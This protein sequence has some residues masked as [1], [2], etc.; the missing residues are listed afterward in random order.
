[1]QLKIGPLT[2]KNRL[3]L[4]PMVEVTDLPYRL[5]CRKAGAAMAYTEM[6]YISAILHENTKTQRLMK[7]IPS[8]HPLGIQITGNNAEEF[9]KAIP[10]LRPYDVVDIN[11]GCPSIRIIGNA[12]GSYL[13][14]HPNKIA[15]MIKILKDSGLTVTAKIRL[16]FK[17]NNVLKIA[18]QIEKA[19]AD[20]L[21]IHA[22]LAHQGANIPA[23]WRWIAK[24]KKTIGIPV[25]GNGDIFSPKHVEEMLN[26]ADGAMLAR[27]ALGDPDIFTRTL[28]YLKTGKEQEVNFARNLKSFQEYL[29][30]AK[31]HQVIDL[32]RIKYLGVNFLRNVPGASKMRNQIMQTKSLLEIQEFTKAML[33][34]N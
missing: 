33:E 29:K 23:D 34:K 1:M 18:K 25:I 4:A 28:K 26:I 15:N 11:C 21:T 5:I 16:G 6:L 8:E 13:L 9:Q 27:G 17:H 22:R 32:Q 7:T 24:V 19:D 10:H 14:K 20:A 31:K 3:F 2:F 30:L 12:A